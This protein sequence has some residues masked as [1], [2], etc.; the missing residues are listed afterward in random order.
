M[1]RSKIR[2]ATSWTFSCSKGEW[3]SWKVIPVTA[4]T[5]SLTSIFVETNKGA[6]S[7]K[8]WLCSNGF[9]ATT[10]YGDRSQQSVNRYLNRTRSIKIV[11]CSINN[12]NLAEIHVK[13][14]DGLL[15]S[16]S[17]D[18]E[19]DCKELKKSGRDMKDSIQSNDTTKVGKELNPFGIF[20]GV[21]MYQ[22]VEPW[23][24]EQYLGDAIF[25]PAGCPQQVRNRQ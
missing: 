15:T 14:T 25:V 23:T 19:V 12:A 24:F 22:N 3:I 6:D 2:K 9:L 1:F 11:F 7:L 17:A 21:K 4:F 10:I 20:F 13:E 8:Y 5:T 16:T 18:K